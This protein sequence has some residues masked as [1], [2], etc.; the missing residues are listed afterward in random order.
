MSSTEGPWQLWK[1]T[2][3]W[4]PLHYRWEFLWVIIS[5]SPLHTSALICSLSFNRQL[6]TPI[7]FTGNNPFK[8]LTRKPGFLQNATNHFVWENSHFSPQGKTN[9]IQYEDVNTMQVIAS[10]ACT[11]SPDP[12]F[13]ESNGL[14]FLGPMAAKAVRLAS[15]CCICANSN[16]CI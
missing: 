2:T 14:F 11:S 1:A 15:L 5:F 8:H 4:L 12:T 7:K 9:V 3:A 13:D 6:H 16:C 10:H